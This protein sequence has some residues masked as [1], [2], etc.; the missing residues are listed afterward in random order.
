LKSTHGNPR[1]TFGGRCH[2]TRVCWETI[3]ASRSN[4]ELTFST[5]RLRNLVNA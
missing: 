5:D 3:K 1:R 2:R 4:S